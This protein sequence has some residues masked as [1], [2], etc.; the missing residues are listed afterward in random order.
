MGK[1][2]K[3]SFI[4]YHILNSYAMNSDIWSNNIA[5]GRGLSTAQAGDKWHYYLWNQPSVFNFTAVTTGTLS[6]NSP[7]IPPCT[8]YSAPYNPSPYAGNGHGTIMRFLMAPIT[9][10]PSFKM[11]YKNRYQD[12]LNGAL[13]CENILAHY[14]CVVELFS[15]EIKYM[16]D[17]SNPP[18]IFTAVLGDYDTN[19]TRLRKIIEKR[20]DY[21]R[22]ALG[23][24]LN[25]Y[26]MGKRYGLTVDVFPVDAGIVKLNTEWLPKYKWSGEYY[27]TQI[28]LKATPTSTNHVFH[29]WEIKNHT[30]TTNNA[31]I[32]LDSIA[33]DF[34]QDDEI[35]AVFT[36]ITTDI[37]MPTG[38]TPNG[39]GN[40]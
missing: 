14:D 13:K 4:D 40:N 1:L 16:E 5:F 35:V 29:H 8:S 24:N 11:D 6:Y 27:P 15:K 12:L 9:G 17:P 23:S 30:S 39:D 32:S 28:N 10:N 22:G 31:P 7:F 34:N 36:D 2:D 33:I 3:E 21:M 38:F 18:S 37:E 20:C 19:T 26:A 25:C